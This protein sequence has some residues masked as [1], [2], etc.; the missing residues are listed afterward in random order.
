M[1]TNLETLQRSRRVL[2]QLAE[3]VNKRDLSELGTKDL[4][5]LFVNNGKFVAALEA[6]LPCESEETDPLADEIV[7]LGN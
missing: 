6:K 1:T 3:E 4:I 2:T 7:R 5:T